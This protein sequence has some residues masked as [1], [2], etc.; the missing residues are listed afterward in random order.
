[1]TV[2]VA[3]AVKAGDQKGPTARVMTLPGGAWPSGLKFQTLLPKPPNLVTLTWNP[4][5]SSS[6]VA[7]VASIPI[8]LGTLTSCG[9]V[10]T[11]T[12]TVWPGWN[13]A[14]AAGSWLTT[15]P[16]GSW[17]LVSDS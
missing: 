12:T 1:M 2:M 6:R 14:P 4:A 10:D 3:H 5:F 9:P 13:M 17:L 7:S 15:V 11:R 8:G 16:A